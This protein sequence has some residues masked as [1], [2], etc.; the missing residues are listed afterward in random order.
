MWV[1]EAASFGVDERISK[2]GL[3]SASPSSVLGWVIA[4][5]ANAWEEPR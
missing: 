1:L 3:F 4:G 5:L 2:R